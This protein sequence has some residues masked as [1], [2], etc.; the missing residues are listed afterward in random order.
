MCTGCGRQIPT[1]YNVCPHCGRPQNA[2]PGP[3]Y[4]QPTQQSESL[5]GGLTIIL[6]IVAFLIPLVGIIIGIIWGGAGSDPER[7]HVGKNCLIIGI[8][9]IVLWVVIGCVLSA[10]LAF[11][12][13]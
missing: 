1:E 4:P 2:Q 9:S 7:R 3:V 12:A 5:G 13:V 6:Y 11:W 8:I 10:S